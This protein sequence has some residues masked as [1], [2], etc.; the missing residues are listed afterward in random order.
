M[1]YEYP[2]SCIH[3]CLC[4]CVC[5]CVLVPMSVCVSV[6]VCVCSQRIS[7]GAKDTEQPRCLC[8]KGWQNSGNGA[9]PCDEVDMTLC[10]NK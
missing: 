9:A 7:G 3:V 10:P 6:C 1:R 5:K 8:H 4:V 2:M